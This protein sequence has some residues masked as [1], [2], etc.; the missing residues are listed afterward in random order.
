MTRG[1]P[2]LLITVVPDSGTGELV[3]L[4]GKMTI[5][6]ENGKDGGMVAGRGLVLL[7]RVGNDLLAKPARAPDVPG[8]LA[9]GTPVGY[10]AQTLSIQSSWP[11][12]RTDCKAPVKVT[13]PYLPLRGGG[14]GVPVTATPTPLR[15]GGADLRSPA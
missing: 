6:I 1:T 2:D 12:I 4:A 15:T 3:G 5:K 14:K 8:A 11:P 13:V 9:V 10:C 7:G